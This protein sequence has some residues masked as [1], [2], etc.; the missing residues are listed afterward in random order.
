MAPRPGTLQCA[1]SSGEL[2]ER[3]HGRTDIKQFYAGASLM[4]RAV[5]VPQ[6][7][8]SNETVLGSQLLGRVRSAHVALAASVA[9]FSN[10]G[11]TW[12]TLLT[13]F[14]TVK[15]A[16]VFG[17]DGYIA[18]LDF[19]TVVD[20]SA[21]DIY[22]FA[23]AG[24]GS[25]R[26]LVC[27]SSIDYVSWQ[28]FGI[29]FGLDSVARS[30]RWTLPPGHT[31]QARYVRIRL[32][33]TLF[34]PGM[35]TLRGFRCFTVSAAGAYRVRRFTF[36]RDEDYQLV[37]SVNNID[38]WR[39]K[40]WKA[41]IPFYITAEQIKTFDFAQRL[42]T[43]LIFHEEF[44]PQ[45]IMRQGADDEWTCWDTLFRRL[46][47]VDY[48]ASY[49]NGLP[50]IYSAK[51]VNLTLPAAFALTVGGEETE[52]IGVQSTEA[53]TAAAIKSAVERLPSVEPGITVTY[54]SAAAA[55]L[56]SMTGTGNEGDGW[57]MTGR[58][59]EPA[60]TAIVVS[61]KQQGKSGGEPL[62][63]SARGY[64]SCGVFWQQ[65]L[66]MGGFRSKPN[67]WL[68]SRL[69]DPLDL[70]IEA[71]ADDG[72]YLG[73]LDTDGAERIDRI[74]YGTFLH[75]LTSDG[76]YYLTDPA[77]TRQKPPN[78]RRA[79]DNGIRRGVGV[80]RTDIATI[81]VHKNGKNIVEFVYSDAEQNYLSTNISVLSSGLLDAVV[82][83]AY[84]GA[85]AAD[86]ANALMVVNADGGMRV[87]AM[88]KQQAID[89]APGRFDTDGEI[90]SVCATAN[91]EI[92]FGVDRL[93]GG[94]TVQMIE[95]ID[96]A[97]PLDSWTRHEFGAPQTLVSGLAQDYEGA[98][99]WAI[100]DDVP[101]GP[102]TVTGG[103]ITLPEPAQTV[104]VGRW[105]PVC[106]RTLPVPKDVGERMIV[107]RP[108]RP[109]TVR[110]YVLRTSSL[111]IGSETDGP[112][113]VDLVRFGDP[114]DQPLLTNPV[115]RKVEIE[116]LAGYSD[117][118]KVSF[119][120]LRPGRLTVRDVTIE[121]ER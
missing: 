87:F 39:N 35:V 83:L 54:D 63:S 100:A 33:G 34:A 6:S 99:V 17:G 79:T 31:R 29:G 55:Y 26:P 94:L 4:Q 2:D 23:S 21:V 110:A 69:G 24:T 64:A 37:F 48:G 51:L 52:A 15:Q 1:W 103:A 90:R 115:S 77:L 40:A 57:T 108:V 32:A 98:T 16:G 96:P 11:I 73:A 72:A 56:I 30:R 71:L 3:L 75:F 67:A 36:S 66:V 45:H 107:D 109:H 18:H 41:S 116:G 7:G 10:P 105:W 9:D 85:T 14:T 43:L 53:G 104:Y 84:R 76:E 20:L 25:G 81:F 95:Q 101:Y 38:V 59:L 92:I 113:E 27:D 46:P 78:I 61:K 119:T 60:S 80:A 121:V 70:N 88:F 62:M 102:F 47:D 97:A 106:V 118:G 65:R 42:D 49:S 112:F 5:A 86:D 28:Q 68:A 117:E 114:I 8:F 111:A 93:V 120:Q 91:G 58:M 13:D 44:W 74:V 50:A 89:A 19:G 22:E 12:S 82:D